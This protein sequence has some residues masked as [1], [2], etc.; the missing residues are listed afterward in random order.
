MKLHL[1]V[2]AEY[3][4]AIRAGT[5]R[6]EYRLHNPYWRKRLVSMPSGKKREFEAVVIH[7]GYKPGPENKIEFPW[8]GWRLRGIT[9]PH[10]GADEVTVFAIRLDSMDSI[11]EPN[12]EEGFLPEIMKRFPGLSREDA[13]EAWK[14]AADRITLA[15]QGPY[16]RTAAHSILNSP[17]GREIAERIAWPKDIGTQ[18]G[19]SFMRNVVG[20]TRFAGYV[21]A[22][23]ATAEK[24]EGGSHAGTSIPE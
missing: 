9:H 13:I 2:K 19:E 6:E 17:E 4:A 1:H 22:H 10:F 7:N 11:H 16:A 3:F 20:N 18:A 14:V 15:I 12:Q 5:K 24:I 8:R 23:I 21:Q